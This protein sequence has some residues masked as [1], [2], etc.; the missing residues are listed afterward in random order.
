MA[1]NLTRYSE[2]MAST[3][4]AEVGDRQVLLATSEALL[5]AGAFVGLRIHS[6]CME[7]SVRLRPPLIER[8]IHVYVFSEAFG[9]CLSPSLL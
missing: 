6:G 5:A 9:P 8:H 1:R 4:T 3:A 2:Y 7:F